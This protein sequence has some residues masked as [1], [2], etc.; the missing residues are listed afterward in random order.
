MDQWS[1]CS[2]KMEAVPPV[3]MCKSNMY[4][5]VG[6]L[7][8]NRLLGLHGILRVIGLYRAMKFELTSRCGSSRRRAA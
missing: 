3:I 5:M 1:A 6:V 8:V 2:I 4:M 7:L